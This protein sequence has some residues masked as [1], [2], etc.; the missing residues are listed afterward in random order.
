LASKENHIQPRLG[1]GIYLIKDVS[2][3]L[4]LDYEKVYRW[5]VSYWSGDLS[6]T[7]NYTF[8]DVDNRAIN[9]YSLIEFYTFFKLREKGISSTQ[10][11]KLH[12]EL[13]NILQTPYPFAIAQDYY[14]EKRK[15]KKTKKVFVYYTYLDSLMKLSPKKQFFFKFLD[16]FLDRIEFDEN[17]LAVRFYPLHNSRNV[18]VDPKR[19]FGQP[20]ING[21]NIKT[22]TVFSLFRGGESLED[23][24]TLYNIP[25]EK[26]KDAINFQNAA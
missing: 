19:Q 7:I 26:V 2:K 1:E 23:I 13:A 11:K 18:V 24:S 9:F 22:Q 21:T 10:I 6:E 5:I 8:G 12:S 16:E 15:T 14:V 17:N 3:I 20:I 4:Q 25:I